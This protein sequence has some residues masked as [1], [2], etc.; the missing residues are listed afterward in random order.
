MRACVTRGFARASLVR[1]FGARA[2]AHGGYSRDL[3]PCYTAIAA[4]ATPLAAERALRA[5]QLACAPPAPNEAEA[6]ARAAAML[7]AA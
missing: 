2:Q 3:L 5:L 1:C 6:S 7:D 4:H